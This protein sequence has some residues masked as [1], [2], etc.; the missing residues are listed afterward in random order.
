MTT[1]FTYVLEPEPPSLLI[2]KSVLTGMDICPNQKKIKLYYFAYD[3][4]GQN[5][6]ET[7]PF[8]HNSHVGTN[9]NHSDIS[10]GPP[11][12]GGPPI[13]STHT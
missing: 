10:H 12:H 8:P 5:C 7:L 3:A 9:R 13:A 11:I 6:Q 1:A 2:R 4:A